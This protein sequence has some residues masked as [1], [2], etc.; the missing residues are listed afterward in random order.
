MNEDTGRQSKAVRSTI[1]WYDQYALNEQETAFLKYD[2]GRIVSELESTHADY[3]AV[4][5]ANQ[6]SVAY[7]PSAI[8]PQHPAL[9]GK[10]YFGELCEGLKRKG[11][12]VVAYINWL[13]SRHPEW[14]LVPLTENGPVVEQEFPLAQWADPSDAD[15]RVQNVP[16]GKW[17][18]PCINTPR[19]EQIVAVVKEICEQYH[20]HAFHLDMFFNDQICACPYC[21]PILRDICGREPVTLGNVRAHWREYIDWR[22]GVTTKLMARLAEILHNH[23]VLAAH[24]GHYPLWLSSIYGQDEAWLKYLDVYVS[25]IFADLHR[26]SL[27][28]RWHHAV[29]LPSWELLTSTVPEHCHLSLPEARWR[30]SSALCKTNGCNVLGPCGVGAYPDTTSSPRLLETVRKGLD[31]FMSDADLAEGAESAAKIALVYSWATRK[32]YKQGGTGW[33]Q[34]ISG[35]GHLLIEE[36]LPFD[37]ITAEKMLSP[38]FLSRFELVILPDNIY[39]S[40]TACDAIEAYVSKGGKIIMTGETSFGDEKGFMR[41]RMALAQTA[42]VQWEK[43]LDG[44]F[45][46]GAGQEPE[47]AMGEFQCVYANGETLAVRVETDPAGSVANWHDPLPM[48]ASEWPV[49]VRTACGKGQCLYVAFGIGCYYQRFRH[50]GIGQFMARLVDTVLP[51]RQLVLHGAR[52]IEASVWRQVSNGRFII[53]LANRSQCPEDMGRLNNVAPIAGVQVEFDAPFSNPKVSSRGADVHAQVDGSRVKLTI[54]VMD[55][56]A[57]IVIEP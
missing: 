42:G 10:D 4:Y 6:F 57:A 55:A 53:H 40:G 27:N 35:W 26:S 50:E 13:E 37:I 47:P 34:E 54:P 15:K 45:A 8:W 12:K 25:E 5:A 7:Y 2:P 1:Y 19:A 20:P 44:Y 56:Y 22:A 41:T 36:G 23:G 46:I 9:H 33:S 17:R 30:L 51:E 21:M 24:N 49:A 48:Q 29:G 43:S 39:L 16:G 28:I 11:K 3:I 38:D 14:Y 31:D 32:Y 18:F 52:M